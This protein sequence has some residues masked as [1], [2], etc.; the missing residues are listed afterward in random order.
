[1]RAWEEARKYRGPKT[2]KLKFTDRWQT[3][4]IRSEA[5]MIP[6]HSDDSTGTFRTRRCGGKGCLLCSKGM[7]PTARIYFLCLVKDKEHWIEL[8]P[9]WEKVFMKY[10]TEVGLQLR[11][12]KN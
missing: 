11:I 10:E 9:H 7:S 3:L 8:L 5:T 2:E 4:I 12:R 6:M 1:M